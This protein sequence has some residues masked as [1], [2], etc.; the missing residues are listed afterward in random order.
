MP[1]LN[2]RCWIYLCVEVGWN[3]RKFWP[4]SD[5]TVLKI[6]KR[7]MVILNKM[8]SVF[9]LSP[10][11]VNKDCNE[12]WMICIT[13]R[14]YQQFTAEDVFNDTFFPYVYYFCIS[15]PVPQDFVKM[16]KVFSKQKAFTYSIL[17]FA[18]LVSWKVT[19]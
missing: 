14:G 6:L 2:D 1:P 5:Y 7:G 15:A 17:S 12:S 13:P 3:L 16:N 4:F 18:T 19:S 8:F 11:F 10:H 9:Y